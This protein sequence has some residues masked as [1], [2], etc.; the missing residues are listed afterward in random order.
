MAPGEVTKIEKKKGNPLQKSKQT[1]HAK[2]YLG[3]I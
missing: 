2:N 1:P 3:R